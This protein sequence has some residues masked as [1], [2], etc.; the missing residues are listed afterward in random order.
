MIV[1]NEPGY[2]KPG[3]YGIRIENL[4]AVVEL[5]PQPEGAERRTL[6]FTTLTVVPYERRLIEV[7]LLS[8]EERVFVDDYHARVRELLAPRVD[9]SAA[10]YLRAATEPLP[11]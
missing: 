8:A 1:S 4:I 11:G 7:G 3:E 2:Y 10:R 5:E 9:A 6:G